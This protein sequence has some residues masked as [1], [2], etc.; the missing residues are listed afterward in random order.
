MRRI[1]SAVVSHGGASQD[2]KRFKS[3]GSNSIKHVIIITIVMVM[4]IIDQVSIR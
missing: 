3:L 2:F 4:V 1:C